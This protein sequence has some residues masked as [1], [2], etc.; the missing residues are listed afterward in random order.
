MLSLLLALSGTGGCTDSI[1]SPVVKGLHPEGF[2]L[3][4]K[5]EI[6][7]TETLFDYM[8]GG[9]EAYFPFGFKLLFLQGYR[10]QQN[11]IQMI[12]E[13]YDMGTAKGAHGIFEKYTQGKGQKVQDLGESAWADKYTSL[14][15][16]G[17]YFFRISSDPYQ[18]A[19]QEATTKD[20]VALS[21][22]IDKIIKQ[23]KKK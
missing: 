4:N 12:M 15:L 6:Y 3:S 1:D 23:K 21:R 7:N 13:A 5:S 14:F 19:K 16:R 2:S 22:A 18:G 11:G 17:Q 9:A 20:L 8:N 10:N